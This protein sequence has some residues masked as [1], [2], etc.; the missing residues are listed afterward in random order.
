M[1]KTILIVEDNALNMKLFDQLLQANGYDTIQSIDG[2]DVWEIVKERSPDL[3]I[4]DIQLPG[5]SGLEITRDLKADEELKHIPIIAVT[6]FAMK[7]DE[8]VIREA[9]CD[10]YIAKPISVPLLLETV[11][12]FLS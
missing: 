8:E 12:K 6:A 9:G 5:R 3:I 2:G 4:M 11:A 7:G 1:T 10:D